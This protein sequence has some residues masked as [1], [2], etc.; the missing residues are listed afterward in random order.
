MTSAEAYILPGAGPRANDHEGGAA[1][2]GAREAEQ[3]GD[4]VLRWRAAHGAVY[5]ASW[6]PL[7]TIARAPTVSCR[8]RLL[9]IYRSTVVSL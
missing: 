8:L 5:D 1:V 6:T 7:L 2:G 4:C 3:R 9:C